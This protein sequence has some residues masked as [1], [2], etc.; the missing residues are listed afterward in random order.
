MTQ[1]AKQLQRGQAPIYVF[2]GE[3]TLLSREAVEW[4]RETHLSEAIV[5]FNFDRFDAAQSAFSVAKVVNAAETPPMMCDRRVVWVQATEVLNLQ[6]KA[7]LVELLDYLE[8]PAPETCLIFEAT[9]R[10]DKGRALWKALTKKNTPSIVIEHEPLKGSSLTRWLSQEAKG[11]KLEVHSE[12]LELILESSEGDL[13]F[14]R[15]SLKKLKLF[16]SPRTQVTLKDVQE[17]IPE[18]HLQ[19]TVWALLDALSMKREGDV[20]SMTHA[21]L[22]QGQSEQGLFA[23]ITKRIRELTLAHAVRAKGG[24]EKQLATLAGMPPFGAKKVLQ[25]IG[26]RGQFSV[27]ELVTAYQMLLLADREM[28]GSKVPPSLV[29]EGLLLNLCLLGRI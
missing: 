8:R 19:T 4:L 11:L 20:L 5:D 21:L 12:A 15:N 25:Q 22:S 18:A 14:M 17:L 29:L 23:L 9:K 7:K 10:L 24:G 13:S 1:W 26:G 27:T 6:A 28:K 2:H 3:E 16:I